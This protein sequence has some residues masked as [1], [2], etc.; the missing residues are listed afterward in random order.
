MYAA[1]ASSR[2]AELLAV[3]QSLAGEGLERA[4]RAADRAGDLAGRSHEAG[5]KYWQ[6]G[7]DAAQVGIERAEK[8]TRPH[9]DRAEEVARQLYDEDA[10]EVIDEKVLPVYA[11][12]VEPHVAVALAAVRDAREVAE[13]RI[14]E[15]ARQAKDAAEAARITAIHLVGETA[16][17]TG[18]H[19]KG[20]K[21]L[22]RFREKVKVL[23]SEVSVGIVCVV[24]DALLRCFCA[25]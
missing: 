1:A 4:S 5:V 24:C 12:K 21:S 18:E 10:R 16:K 13:P 20:V 3:A 11:A 6:V 7:R 25:V 15:G 19:V 23:E 17:A 2:A 22:K 14:R 9:R 8:A